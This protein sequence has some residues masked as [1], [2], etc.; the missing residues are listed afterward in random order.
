MPLG[1]LCQNPHRLSFSG[2]VIL[3]NCKPA[4]LINRS[5]LVYCCFSYEQQGNVFLK[6][7]QG[8]AVI[9]SKTTSAQFDIVKCRC[10]TDVQRRVSTPCVL[11]T[12]GSEKKESFRRACPYSTAP[13][14]CGPTP[15]VSSIRRHRTGG[16]VRQI[17]I[18][19]SHSV[20]GELPLHKERRVFVLGQSTDQTLGYFVQSGRVFDGSVILPHPYVCVTRCMLVLSADEGD[21]DGAVLRSEVVAATSNRQLVYFD[22]GVV[23]DVCQ[24]PFEQPE[25]V[26]LINTGRNG[27]LFVVSFHQGR[28]CAVW[29]ETFQV[30]SQ[31]SGVTS[32]HVD[33]FLRCGSD[34][35]LLVFKDQSAEGQPLEEFLLTDLCGISYAMRR[36]TNRKYMFSVVRTVKPTRT[37]PPP[38]ENYLLTLQ[39][40]E[41]RL[42][43][44]LSVLQELQREVRVKERV[45]RQSVQTL[46][47]VVSDREP[48]LTQP[49]QEGLIALWDCDDESKQGASDDETQDMPAVSSRPRVD[50]LWHRIA[51]DRLVVGVVLTTDG[52]V[53]VAN[54]SLS[55]LTE[56]GQSSTPAVIQTQSQVLW[57][58]APCS[59]SS[60][61]SSSPASTFAE[62]AA[63]RSKQ[64]QHNAGR[65]SDLNT[66]RL[67]VTAVTRLTPLLNS[68][69]VKC[70][71]M[72]HYVQRRNAFALVSNPT[73]VVPALW[74]SCFRYP[75]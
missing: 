10:A 1:D 47:D 51:E 32:V 6:A 66:C 40:L 68:G 35:M 58:P 56:T 18:Q 43:S 22:D 42:Q 12:K 50:K 4:S 17:P 21:G 41:S 3:F 23:K 65:P 63:K 74:S 5:E 67:A 57:L 30:A 7:A 11:V 39:A 54:V 2:G 60:S 15:V 64:Q 70:C 52:S 59:A 9:S 72:L 31:W 62:P 8:A 13:P 28:V 71:V 48:T 19:L 16:E 26:Q 20:A 24:L 55:I 61:S 36:V 37:S 53:P 29:K 25:D 38:S 33:D 46:T 14:C 45:L 75:Q 49:E 69:R 73:P 27:C 34:Q 44:G